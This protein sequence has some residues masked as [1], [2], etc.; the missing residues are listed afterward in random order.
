MWCA[1]DSDCGNRCRYHGIMFRLESEGL[2]L[3]ADLTDKYAKLVLSSVLLGCGVAGTHLICHACFV[4]AVI[5]PPV[6]LMYGLKR[7]PLPQTKA[8]IAPFFP[9]FPCIGL[10]INIFLMF[11]LDVRVSCFAA[12]SLLL[13]SAFTTCADVRCLRNVYSASGGC[14]VSTSS[15]DLHRLVHLLRLRYLAQL[16]SKCH[17]GAGTCWDSV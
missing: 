2:H 16:H 4:S 17:S 14:I 13:G 5:I 10:V 12:V 3:S 1:L 9:A 7:A 11:Q 8:F 6:L 15:L